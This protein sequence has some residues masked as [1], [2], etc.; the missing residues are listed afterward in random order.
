ML[1]GR[2]ASDA[3]GMAGE[4]NMKAWAWVAALSML[5]SLAHADS[6]GEAAKRERERREKVKQQQGTS[7]AAR[8]IRDEDLRAAPA[9]D[10]KGT[11][12]SGAGVA[13]G[14]AGVS[15]PESPAAGTGGPSEVDTIRAGA[16]QRLE[17][18]YAEIAA[19]AGSFLQAVEDYLRCNASQAAPNARCA[20]QAVRVTTLAVSVAVGME[21][22]EDAARQGWLNP[23]EVRAVRQRYGMDDAAWDRLVSYVNQYRR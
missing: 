1:Y 6:L 11:F 9:G 20:A 12:S 7:T 23:G 13:A 22:A 15:V 17:S 8:V 18:S 10:A 2:S 21:H 16:R 19:N 5:G 14:R 4:E 3:Y